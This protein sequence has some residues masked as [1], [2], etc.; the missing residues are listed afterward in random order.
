MGT[1]DTL[2][3]IIPAWR[4][5]SRLLEAIRAARMAVGQGEFVVVACEESRE[6]RDAA[7]AE[8]VA[9]IDS[10]RA[11]R[12]LQ[13]K[14]G[15][16]RA[17]GRILVFL[18][19]DTRLPCDAGS[20][21]RRALELEGVAGGA[22]RLRFNLEHP[23]LDVLAWLSG[24]TLPM[25][26][27]GDQCLFCSRGAYE[28]AGGFLPQS[29]FEDVDFARRLARI[30]KLVRLRAA[31]TTSARRFVRHGPVR[32]LATNALLLLAYHAG[33]SPERLHGVYEPGASMLPTVGTVGHR[34][35]PKTTVRWRARTRRIR[36]SQA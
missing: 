11:C 35:S 1:G 32:Q 13:L 5:G 7:C 20:L 4:E 6:I 30:G 9:W 29:L 33:V 2:S 23:V 25:T 21:I 27:L 18:H 24:M 12:G 16:E 31:V 28:A 17:R 19:A 8:G 3:V 34:R 14:L 36:G 26:F 22:F 10:P 15:A